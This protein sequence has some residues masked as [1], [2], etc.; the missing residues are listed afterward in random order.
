[1]GGR[2]IDCSVDWS[3]DW[4]N[5]WLIDWFFLH[6]IFFHC[7]FESNRGNF[8]LLLFP[9]FVHA[10]HMT[11]PPS[12]SSLPALTGD[13]DDEVVGLKRLIAEVRVN[14]L[15]YTLPFNRIRFFS[16]RVS[17]KN[18]RRVCFLSLS[19]KE[20]RKINV[21]ASFFSLFSF[22]IQKEK[23][24]ELAARIGQ[25]L[26]T[27][28]RLLQVNH[29]ELAQ[30]CTITQDEVRCFFFM[31]WFI[32]LSFHVPSFVC[33]CDS[34]PSVQLTQLR[35]ELSMNKEILRIYAL[36]SPD[37]GANDVERYY[38]GDFCLFWTCGVDL[39]LANWRPSW[40]GI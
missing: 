15:I 25:S 33:Q 16:C 7:H 10:L 37:Y 1:M 30:L 21:V 11:G 14:R 29:D 22:T 19:V 28:N 5:E 9:D 35:H 38:H 32:L 27:K 3:S 24:L 39:K 31:G 6:C 34:H 23:D 2:L 26:L 36:E 40:Q 17:F 8:F 20:T 13:G 4:L 12:M 18:R